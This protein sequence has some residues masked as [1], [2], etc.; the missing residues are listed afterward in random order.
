MTHINERQDEELNAR[1]KEW[2]SSHSQ[3]YVDP[4]EIDHLGKK[5]DMADDE[6]LLLLAKFDSNFAQDG[7]FAQQRGAPL[8]SG[9]L[10]KTLEGKKGFR[11]RMWLGCSYRSAMS[12]RWGSELY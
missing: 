11:G 7:Y 4:G 3:D 12:V 1:S 2:W 8:F 5:A 10:P 9:L 6:L